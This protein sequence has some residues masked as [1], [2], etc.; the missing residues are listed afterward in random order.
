MAEVQ[1]SGSGVVE[2]A[3][4]EPAAGAAEGPEAKAAGEAVGEEA[5]VVAAVAAVGSTQ[6]P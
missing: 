1:A 6:P 4:A 2:A 3:R 5:A